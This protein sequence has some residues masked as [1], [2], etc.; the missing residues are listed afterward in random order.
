MHQ[1]RPSVLLHQ[2]APP[3]MV[4]PGSLGP[5]ELQISGLTA[6]KA[7]LEGSL[8]HIKAEQAAAAEQA[9]LLK[10]RVAELEKLRQN[11]A[12]QLQAAQSSQEHASQECTVARQKAAGLA[13]E[14]E[15]KDCRLRSVRHVRCRV[16]C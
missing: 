11:L 16:I 8:L 1:E 2:E 3:A 9:A 7:A 14:L 13:A 15:V 5:C 10:G 4:G 6:A 12:P